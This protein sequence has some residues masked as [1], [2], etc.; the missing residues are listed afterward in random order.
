MA[1][2]RCKR[3]PIRGDEGPDRRCVCRRPAGPFLASL[4]RS[5][6][7]PNTSPFRWTA[8]PLQGRTVDTDVLYFR[9]LA[10]LYHQISG[11]GQRHQIRPCINYLGKPPRPWDFY[12]RMAYAMEVRFR[13]HAI[14][15]YPRSPHLPL[16]A[17]V[18]FPPSQS[19]SQACEPGPHARGRACL[20][21]GSTS[22]DWR[23]GSTGL[24]VS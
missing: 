22:E 4:D 24:A 14:R 18:R 3:K 7:K 5:S 13:R 10:Q 15:E 1:L 6:R 20:P 2:P 12:I 8:F 11:C 21:P 16:T 23:A 19:S 9:F 17:G